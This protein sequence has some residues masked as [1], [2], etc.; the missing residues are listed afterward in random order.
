MRLKATYPIWLD[1]ICKHAFNIKPQP[2]QHLPI[3]S[4]GKWLLCSFQQ[5]RWRCIFH[6][7]DIYTTSFL[8]DAQ[9]MSDSPA[10]ALTISINITLSL[11]KQSIASEGLEET[12][13]KPLELVSENLSLINLVSDFNIFSS[14]YKYRLIFLIDSY[15]TCHPHGR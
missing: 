8:H 9:K 14:S 12:A 3:T 1:K 6:F 5:L 4:K 10:F 15:H 13:P 7:K 2:Q 11:Q